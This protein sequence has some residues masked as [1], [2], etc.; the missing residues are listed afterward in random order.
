M[1][2][3]L[4]KRNIDRHFT[5]GVDCKQG[6]C[7]AAMFPWLFFHRA[8]KEISLKSHQAASTNFIL[9]LQA[10][11]IVARRRRSCT[12]CLSSRPQRLADCVVAEQE[13]AVCVMSASVFDFTSPPEV[14]V[15]PPPHPHPP[16]PTPHHLPPGAAKPRMPVLGRAAGSHGSSFWQTVPSPQRAAM[17]IRIKS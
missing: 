15:C 14:H 16:P 10:L 4:D 9:S 13:H 8:L 12:R 17:P 5:L 3:D 7:L 11:D 6:L 2:Q 1:R